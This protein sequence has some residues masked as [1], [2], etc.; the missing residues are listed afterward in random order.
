MFFSLLHNLL[1]IAREII[2]YLILTSSLYL[3]TLIFISYY[4][5][6]SIAQATLVA[7]QEPPISML[8]LCRRMA[9]ASDCRNCDSG[10]LGFSEL[11]AAAGRSTADSERLQIF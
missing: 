6:H 8:Y 7:L 1:F 3:F 5:C 2:F 10:A 9:G 11:S 4:I